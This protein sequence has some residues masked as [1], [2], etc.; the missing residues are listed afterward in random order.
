MSKYKK[1]SYVLLSSLDHDKLFLG[2]RITQKKYFLGKE[3][4]RILHQRK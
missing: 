1:K 3:K 4:V 2:Q